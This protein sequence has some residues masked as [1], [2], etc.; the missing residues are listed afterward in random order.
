M[1]KAKELDQLVEMKRREFIMLLG[2]V[3]V[4]WSLASVALAGSLAAAPL[5]RSVLIIDQYG[6]GLP[7][8]AGISSGIRATVISGSATQVSV[9]HEQLDL[10]RFRGPVYEHSLNA[11]FRV[12]YRD[13]QVGVIIAVG[14]AALEYV[15]R[16]RAEL[17]PEVPVVFTFVD[18]PTITQL[19]LPPD[20]T[21]NTLQSHPRDMV[22]VARTLVPDIKGIALVGDPPENQTYY[23]DLKKEVP[24]VAA[25]LEFIDLTGLTMT[26]LR[27]RVAM[28]PD[29]TAILHTSIYSDGEGNSLIPADAVALVAEMANR[30]IV[31]DLDTHFGRG[32]VGGLITT[33]SSLGEAAAKIALR[34]LNGEIASN[35]PIEESELAKPI[36]DWRQLKRFGISEA[37]LPPG[38]EVRFRELTAWEQYRWQIMLIAAALVIQ[39]TLIIWLYYEHRRRRKA[40]ADSR[41]AFAKFADMNRIATAGEL[42]ASIAHEIKQPLAAMVTNANAGLRWL[43]KETPDLDETRKAMTNVVSDGHRASEVIGSVQAMF[44]KDNQ[45]KTTVDL[46]NVIQDVL[47]LVRGELQTQGILVQSGLTRPLP[48]VLGHSGQLQQVI[49]NLVRNAADAMDSVSGRTR[50]LRMKTAIHDPDSVLLSV[51][52]SGAGIAPEDIDRIFESF[53]T[54]KSQGMGMGLSICRSIIEAHDGR[55]WASSSVDHGSVFNIVLPAARPEIE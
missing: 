10:A 9:Y 39:T 1:L 51:E 3:A 40:E 53:F 11:H 41:S 42:T 35:I 24:I 2:G 6:P 30:P 45:A 19:K 8:S 55:L 4:A 13:K 48:L 20:V 25:D 12:K 15:L 27:K 33:S 5:P 28:L 54:T 38:S 18:K 47:G 22:T 46:N 34:I 21:G 37:N 31:V 16:S 26:E 52:D 17:W 7:F 43:A 14:P 49:L 50:A 36:F 23:R 44:K 32:T 29:H